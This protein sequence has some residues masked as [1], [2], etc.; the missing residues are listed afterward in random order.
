MRMRQI[1]ITAV[2]CFTIL[3]TGF[4]QC[5][6]SFLVAGGGSYCS[7][8]SGVTITL[9]GS[10]AP[11]ATTV[12]YQLKRG[13]T[14]VGTALT[15]TGA[16]LSWTGNTT[17]GT[18][19]VVATDQ[20]SLCATTMTGNAVVTVL[21]LP[22]SF[23]T[24]GTATIC[25]GQTTAT[26]TL[27]GSTSGISYQLLLSGSPFG[28]AITGTGSAL[29]WPGQTAGGTYT[30]L[31][32]NPTTLCTRTMAGSAVVTVN[33]SP[34]SFTLSGGAAF[35]AG[36]TGPTL[37]LSGSE[38]GV[39]YQLKL[40]GSTNSGTAKNGTGSALTWT[41][42]NVAGTYSVVATRTSCTSVTMNGAAVV[43][44]NPL[45][46]DFTVGGGGGFCSGGTGLTVTMSGSESGISYQL[47]RGA[48][49]VG[50]PLIGTG[51]PL[52]FPAQTTA[53]TYTVVG[54]NTTTNCVKTLTGSAVI[55]VN[56]LPT[57]YTVSGTGSMCAGTAGR[58][59]S[60]SN[61]Q[62]G[63]NYQLLVVG[64][65]TVPVVAGT[66]T[67]LSWANQT[68][69]GA[70]TV[71]ATNATTNCTKNMTGT[72]TITVNPIPQIFTVGGGIA[73]SP[74]TVVVTLPGSA[75]GINYQLK[76]DGV[77]VGA[78]KAG[79]GSSLSWGSQAAVGIYTI[80]ATNAT[81]SCFSTM[82]GS[83]AIYN[84]PGLFTVSGS[85]SY[86]P[87]GTGVTVTLSGSALG[88]NYQL[89]IGG[90]NY[91]ALF[92]GTGSSLIWTNLTT[93]GSYTVVASVAGASCNQTMTGAASVSI[94]PVPT[95]YQVGGGGSTC[96]S[97]ASLNITLGGSEAGVTYQLFVDGT[98]TQT[99]M[100]GTGSL[101]S[102]S[103]QTIGAYTVTA[104]NATTGCTSPMSGSSTIGSGAICQIMSDLT[105]QYRYDNR[106]RMIAKKVP[107]ADWVYMVY[108]QRDRVVMTQDANQRATSQWLFIK[109]DL[110]N[111][112][113]LTGLT[114]SANTQAQ[115]QTAVDTYYSNNPNN[116]GEISGSI[117][118]GYTNDSYPQ[119]TDPNAYLS[120]TYYDDYSVA[121][122]WGTSYNYV[123]D[124]LVNNYFRQPPTAIL[125]TIGLP[126]SSKVKVLDGTNTWLKSVIYYDDKYR[127]I[128]TKADNYKGAIDRTS[129]LYDFAG[130]VLQTKTY[131]D[132][133]GTN[134]VNVIKKI[135]YDHASRPTKIHENINGAP[136]D[137]QVAQ[138][139]YNELGQMVDK[140][141]HNTGG[142]SFMQSVDY[143]YNIRGWLSSINNAQLITDSGVTNDDTND[144]FGMELAYNTDAGV[145]NALLYNGNISAM[146]WKGPGSAG[147]A[148]QRSYAFTYD[149]LNRLTNASFQANTGAGWTKEANTLNETMSYD[150]NLNILSLQRNQ[151]QRGL[152][153][154]T[155]TSA[156]QNVDNLTYTY[157][158]G[159]QLSKVED[160]NATTI[161][162]G[163]FKNGANITTEYTYDTNGSLT[164]DKNKGID[165][166]KYNVLNK[167][168]RVKF[169]D[170]RFITYAYDAA[171]TK[172]SMKTYNASAVVQTTTEYVNGFVYTNGA[173][174]FFS[175]PEG[176]VVKNGSNYE[177]QYAI[178]DHL[179]NTRILFTSAAQTPT[180]YLA[181]MESENYATE[182]TVFQNLTNEVPFVAAN[183][184]A[185]G[186]EVVR[187]NQTNPVG[188]ARSLKVY[189]GDK[190][191]ME[192]YAYYESSSGFGS[193]APLTTLVTNIASAFGG[194][195]GGVGE[196]GLIYNGV[197]SGL[198]GFG[199]GSNQGDNQP[200]AYLNYIL[201]DQGYKVVDMGWQPV[202]A[203]ANFAKQKITMP[204]V[205]VKE[206]GYIFVYL[207]YE[208]QSANYVYFDEMKVTHTKTNVI[209]YN[210][211]YPF[212]LQTGNSWTREGNSNK[213]LNNGKE[214]QDD[215]SL[216]WLDYGARMYD[217]AV[218]R[219]TSADPLADK[220]YKFSP[221]VYAGNV[222]TVAIDPDGKKILFVN[223][224]WNGWIGGVIGSSTAGKEYWGSGF[225]EAAQDFFDDRSAVSESNYIDG[226]SWF[227]G[228]SSGEQREQ[229]GYEYAVK[230]YSSLIEGLSEDETFK[231]VTHSEGG[232][233]G[234]G[235]ARYL[236]EKGHKVET[237]LHLSTDEG[238]EFE[239]PRAPKTY[240]LSYKGDW[241]TGNKEI[242][243]GVD[244]YG[245]VDRFARRSD[246]RQYAH[247]QTK[248]S[249]VFKYAKALIGLA[250]KGATGINVTETK[251]GFTFEII[252]DNENE[253]DNEQD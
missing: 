181:T 83:A 198:G 155:I 32:T 207:S 97:G 132:G 69:A 118:H 64:L 130:R 173:L 185:G 34:A 159:N 197:N 20:T 66:G 28:V 243:K 253:K 227:G 212:G 138:Y 3:T 238:D 182:S 215:F 189:A 224:Y 216:N 89:Q 11:G 222:P 174:N 244:V 37:T 84:L 214:L 61:S 31:A 226:S 107:G 143:R 147:V 125:R 114:T 127:T 194:V 53:G 58:T 55:T 218:G 186:N 22:S 68:T 232:A 117:V 135:T 76:K 183:Q 247:G 195:N 211:Y 112:P 103:T 42:T 86:C 248:T 26:P 111:R 104:T 148:D 241:V 251:T 100:A 170:G 220:Y 126:T 152:S 123:N 8:G 47:K 229:D 62:V 4:S 67:A 87:G 74:G 105:F 9:S 124:G 237:L 219:W 48:T 19:T 7:G 210:E 46:L 240:Q 54:T 157:A 128:Q 191:D 120:A 205:S 71:V 139:V 15:G 169:T 163:D 16:A 115:M 179:G 175:S 27:S 121:T 30:V 141:L 2:L 10:Q 177:Y 202:P 93:V 231:L 221:Y 133:G 101:L 165:S 161:G 49:L 85:G 18:Y 82:A 81:T 230:N 14:L 96:V 5:P 60:L 236:I 188:P 242:K 73:C 137:Q 12:T 196:S 166:V 225:T 176:R 13:T 106:S 131:H 156:V 151:N 99:P 246:Q 167:V 17:A 40:N 249:E 25:N 79:T 98:P 203:S 209:Q 44:I 24:S 110:L 178:T 233:F 75:S 171:G 70:Y 239:T 199:L 150:L 102:W 217:P 160:T 149:N 50:S 204:Q 245:V 23:T 33:N 35:C 56:A 136:S 162:T 57:A 108:D 184:T 206:A 45:P 213:F 154:T 78:V 192:V 77:N 43:S 228:D 65:P 122:T 145:S 38:S 168:V 146:K 39:S 52:T 41:N 193:N 21:A 119:I 134:Q 208:N 158:S 190:V 29:T 1:Y 51:S 250:S 91:G 252:R 6:Q 201:F 180:V 187:M 140:K 80:D 94:N 223:G 200:A 234:A 142:A 235:I 95:A 129:N 172:L 144:Y 164:A 36:L 88:I 59:I 153:G 92:N 63:V 72:A 109:Y 113:V 90:V 116:W